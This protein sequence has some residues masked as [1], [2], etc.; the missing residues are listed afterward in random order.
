MRATVEQRYTEALRGT[1]RDIRSELTG[2]LQQRQRKDIRIHRYQTATLM[3]RLDHRV[4]IDDV[5]LRSRVRHNCAHDAIAHDAFTEVN[6]LYLEVKRARTLRGDTQHLRVQARIQLHRPALP[7]RA[8]HEA[9]S[10]RRRRRLI[11]Q[12]SVRNVQA[13]QVLHHG[14]EVQQRLESTLRNLRLV[15]GIRRV[16]AGILHNTTTNHRRR[17]R[18]RVALPIER[19]QHLIFRRQLTQPVLRLI[20]HERGGEIK[21]SLK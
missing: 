3:H 14:L 16:P 11:Q 2:G 10:L 20:L 19:L 9:N 21:G 1:N 4:R 8:S 6:N 18:R 5:A 15:R 17:Q 13:S 7:H 12:G